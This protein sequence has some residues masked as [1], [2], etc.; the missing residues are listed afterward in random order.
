MPADEHVLDILLGE[1]R[2]LIPKATWTAA[3]IGRH[4]AEV[5]GWALARGADAVRTGLED[6]IR[7]DKTRLAASNAELVTLA[8]EA[9]ARHGRRV[10]TAVEAR[11][12]LGIAG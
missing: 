6:N 8:G 5:M 11:S 4:Q 1:L 2:R 7:I 9:V 10:A 12:L 3:G